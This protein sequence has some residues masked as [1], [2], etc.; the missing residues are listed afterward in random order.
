[1]NFLLFVSF[2]TGLLHNASHTTLDAVRESV[3]QLLK[4]EDSRYENGKLLSVC[5]LKKHL[6]THD[7]YTGHLSNGTWF[8]IQPRDIFKILK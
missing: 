6:N 4:D 7:D 2:S 5:G 8:H 1:M 3:Q